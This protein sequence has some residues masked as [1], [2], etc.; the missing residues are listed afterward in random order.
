VCREYQQT[1]TVGG[2]TERAYG[3]ACKQ[4]DGSWKII[5]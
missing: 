2:R 5:N 1:I 4:A 3:T